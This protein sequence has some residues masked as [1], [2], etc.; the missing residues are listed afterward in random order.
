MGVYNVENKFWQWFNKMA[1]VFMISLCWMMCCIPIITIGASNT[2]CIKIVMEISTGSEGS[3]FKD[4]FK[5]F[6]RCFVK[7]TLMWIMQIAIL[8]A[9]YLSVNSCLYLALDMGSKVGWFMLPITGM[10]SLLLILVFLYTWPLVAYVDESNLK[11]IELASKAMMGQLIL[12]IAMIAIFIA[13]I[14]VFLYVPAICI[15]LPFI[16]IYEYAK[17]Y[18]RAFDADTRLRPYLEKDRIRW[19]LVK[20]TKE[21]TEEEKKKVE[22]EVNFYAQFSENEDEE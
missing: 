8:F 21:K 13:S 14:F 20:F 15:L 5:E 1:D 22:E 6:K 3:I 18:I 16:V 11:I 17:L 7:A 2:A 10:I 9:A 19:N 12:S 4:F